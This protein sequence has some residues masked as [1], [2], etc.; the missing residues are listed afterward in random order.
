MKHIYCIAVFLFPVLFV[1]C[2]Q[3]QPCGDDVKREMSLTFELIPE[4]SDRGW[5][6]VS[7]ED[8]LGLS[9]GYSNSDFIE[10]PQEVWCVIT[11]KKNDTLGY[12]RGV[13]TARTFAYFISMD[14]IV[15]LNFQTGI[16]CFSDKFADVDDKS[17]WWKQVKK[18]AKTNSLPI[19]YEPVDIDLRTDLRKK[20]DTVL[21]EK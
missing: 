10:R 17:D 7:W 15:T 4:D 13:S 11:N 19:E 9:E 20:F 14:T 21:K 8:T 16:N 3:S 6:T 5:Y 12:Y 1:S 2:R 18:Y